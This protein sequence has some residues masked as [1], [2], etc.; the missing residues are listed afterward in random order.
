[1]TNDAF[2]DIGDIIARKQITL[3]LGIVVEKRKSTHP[4]GD[5]I[6]E[7]V[8]VIPGAGP[9]SEWVVLQEGDGWTR[10]HIATLPL[11]LHRRETEPLQLS[12]INEEP[13]LY[14][15]L[16]DPDEVDGPPIKAHHVTAS[17][18]DAQDFLDSAEDIVGR[19]PMPPAIYEWIRA[20]VD[21]HHK[22]EVF[23]KRKRD[24]VDVEDHK[25]GKEPIFAMKSKQEGKS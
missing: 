19:V 21:E 7:P 12:L 3:P 11:T 25:F 24:Q 14:V 2:E 17:S 18:Y 5:W 20:F 23:R 10:F 1:M 9:V 22:E 15:I 16:R 4:W 8:E 6:W 13:H